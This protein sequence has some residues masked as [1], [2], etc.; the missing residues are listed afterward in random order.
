MI[1][2]LF[3][4]CISCFFE[5]TKTPSCSFLLNDDD[6]GKVIYSCIAPTPRNSN[7]YIKYFQEK[8]NLRQLSIEIKPLKN[9]LKESTCCTLFQEL[10]LWTRLKAKEYK[11][12]MIVDKYMLLKNISRKEILKLIC[13]TGLKLKF[14]FENFKDKNVDVPQ[15]LL[16]KEEE[17]VENCW[18]EPKVFPIVLNKCIFSVLQ[19]AGSLTSKTRLVFDYGFKTV[20]LKD[21]SDAIEISKLCF[22]WKDF[23]IKIRWG[24]GH[25]TLSII[26]LLK[27]A[28]LLNPP[29]E[30]DYKFL[31]LLE[32]YQKFVGITEKTTQVEIEKLIKSSINTLHVKIKYENPPSPRALKTLTETKISQEKTQDDNSVSTSESL[33]TADSFNALDLF[34]DDSEFLTYPFIMKKQTELRKRIDAECPNIPYYL[35]ACLKS[36][37]TIERV[38]SD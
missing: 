5:K 30:L 28:K 34:D 12:K 16:K 8:G 2:L 29:K 9:A 1:A 22:I 11:V 23:K 15:N 37:K 10:G 26:K 33:D 32:D 20:P 4:Y 38:C 27:D 18:F 36:S 14:V 31:V 19:T 25:D 3:N 24:E 21:A 17:N 6:L 7:I 35:I 13:N